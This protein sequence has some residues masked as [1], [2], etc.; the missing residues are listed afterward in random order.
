MG[1]KDKWEDKDLIC[2]IIN[3]EGLGIWFGFILFHCTFNVHHI[4]TADILFYTSTASKTC[5]KIGKKK[6]NLTFLLHFR[7]I[8]YILILDCFSFHRWVIGY[9]TKVLPCWEGFPSTLSFRAISKCGCSAAAIL[10][11]PT[12]SV[13]LSVKKA[14]I[15]FP[16]SVCWS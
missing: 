10:F 15:F 11:S 8:A 2:E 12:F 4:K 6:Q 14:Y 3:S 13:K 9:I 1:I 5:P 16:F 7:W